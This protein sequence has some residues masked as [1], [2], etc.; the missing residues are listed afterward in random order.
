MANVTFSSP[1]MKK[2]LTVSIGNGEIAR[3]NF[4][5]ELDAVTDGNK[6]ARILLRADKAVD[7]G[8]VM[9]VMN[10]LRGA[11]YGKIALVGLE[12]GTPAQQQ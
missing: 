12:G 2:D 11:G 9:D 3:D 8:N 10:L 1:R 7:Y 4:G 5:P 6:E